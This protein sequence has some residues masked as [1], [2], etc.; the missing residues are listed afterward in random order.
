MGP[1]L[2]HTC[3]VP[4]SGRET[5]RN[6]HAVLKSSTCQGLCSGDLSSVLSSIPPK[7]PGKLTR[8]SQVY[9]WG[10]NSSET[11]KL[12]PIHAVR[13]CQGQDWSAGLAEAITPHC[14]CFMQSC[15]THELP[16]APWPKLN[17]LKQCLALQQ[18][19]PVNLQ[20][21]SLC[22]GAQP[23]CLLPAPYLGGTGPSFT[24]PAG[25]LAANTCLSLATKLRTHHLQETFSEFICINIYCIFFHKEFD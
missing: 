17:V 15:P 8:L 20:F 4:H 13:K 3:R 1:A 2:H 7:V 10:N 11:L 14:C 19:S 23:L 21:Q 24:L 22:L 6:K 12:L 18:L 9:R 16:A 5:D 25:L